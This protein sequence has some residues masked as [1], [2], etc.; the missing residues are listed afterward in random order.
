MDTKEKDNL[1][2]RLNELESGLG[3][4]RAALG[5]TPTD[6]EHN[7]TPDP[8][9]EQGSGVQPTVLSV[10]KRNNSEIT[11]KDIDKLRR[12]AKT[13]GLIIKDMADNPEQ[14]KS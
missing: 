12:C 1:K 8:A 4:L 6:S 9:A 13:K 14:E 7:R 3:A 5:A 10:S 11:S 2:N